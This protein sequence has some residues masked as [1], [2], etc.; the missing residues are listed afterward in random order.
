MKKG[1]R[2]T[3]ILTLCSVPV[4][5]Q[6]FTD[7]ITPKKILGGYACCQGDEIL[8]T[9]ENPVVYANSSNFLYTGAFTLG[10]VSGG[11]IGW[12]IGSMLGVNEVNWFLLG[13]SVVLIAPRKCFVILSDRKLEDAVN[14]YN[15]GLNQL[16]MYKIHMSESFF[17]WKWSRFTV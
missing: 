16:S 14:V 2:S 15:R 3:I 4:F 13:L 12:Q 1:I 7:F 6:N 9:N 10:I 5:S 8:K 17:C 11:T